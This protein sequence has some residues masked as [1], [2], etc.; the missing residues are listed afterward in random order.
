MGLETAGFASFAFTAGATAFF[1]PCSYPLLPGYLAFFLGTSDPDGGTVSERLW[2]AAVVGV[3]VLV[4]FALVYLVLGAIVAAAGSGALSDAV[5]VELPI[6]G[7]LVVLGAAMALGRSV[8]VDSRLRFPERRRSR[9]AY[10]LF[11]V[12]YA[13][14]AAGCTAPLFLAVA[15][16]SVR[17]GAVAAAL[18]VGG[19]AAGMSTLLLA[20]TLLTALGRDAVLDR[21]DPGGDRVQRLAG[22]L[23]L[24]AGATQLSLFVF[25]YDGLAR[26]GIG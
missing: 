24:L 15:G 1:A 8:S 22:V 7:A 9:A 16:V 10:V 12:A 20:V 6:G 5:L 2:R 18:G 26:L 13:A 19:Y 3:H 25:R 11:G 17:G 23:L 4:G 14:A 21:L